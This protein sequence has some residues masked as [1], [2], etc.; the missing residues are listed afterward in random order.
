MR[1]E[2]V[3]LDLLGCDAKLLRDFGAFVSVHA[4]R[5]MIQRGATTPLVAGRRPEP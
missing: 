1:N 3:A 5:P 4:E 2:M